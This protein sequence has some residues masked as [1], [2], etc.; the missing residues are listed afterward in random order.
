M[1]L[2]LTKHKKCISLSGGWVAYVPAAQLS[3]ID[4]ILVVYRVSLSMASASFVIYTG[5]P[6][7]FSAIAVVSLL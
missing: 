4:E 1:P 3:I 5:T 2:A 6:Y 7:R